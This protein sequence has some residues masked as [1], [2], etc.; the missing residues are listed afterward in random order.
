ML[1]VVSTDKYGDSS[2]IVVLPD[3]LKEEGIKI[4]RER[5]KK[6]LES[7]CYL[8][9]NVNVV[10]TVDFNNRIL[11]EIAHL[12]HLQEDLGIT[13]ERTVHCL[14]ILRFIRNDGLNITQEEGLIQV[15]EWIQKNK[16]KI[17]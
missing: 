1:A 15:N 7:Y 5:N 3:E 17:E 4:V 14:E 10:Q 13:N 6:F 11:K 9:Q 2:V 16:E 8:Q 12:R